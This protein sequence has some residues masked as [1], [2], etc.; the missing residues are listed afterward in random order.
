MIV[1][2]FPSSRKLPFLFLCAVVLLIFLPIFSASALD[3]KHPTNGIIYN[4]VENSSLTYECS[5]SSQKDLEC[6]FVQVSVRKKAKPEDLLKKIEIAKK[7]FPDAV[8][9]LKD[10][11]CEL[12]YVLR[13]ISEG[14]I[15]PE[16]ALEKTQKGLISD[17]E[18]FVSSM[19]DLSQ[20][21]REDMRRNMEN[22]SIFCKN[23]SEENYLQIAKSEHDKETKTCLISANHFSQKFNWVSDYGDKSHGAWVVENKPEGPCGVVRLDRFEADKAIGS[24]T[25][26]NYSARKAITNPKGKA[27]PTFS[28]SDMDQNEYP[29]SWEKVRDYKLGCEYIDFSPI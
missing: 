25:L 8:K 2:N 11:D 6:Q 12:F 26:W 23:R 24:I 20:S 21:K 4:T 10:K 1:G 9:E 19:K 3:E 18:K 16:Q 14:K 22:L 17:K 15:T 28:C 13:E 7:Q 29:Y 5:L 27:L